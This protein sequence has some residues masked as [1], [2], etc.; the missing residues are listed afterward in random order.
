MSNKEKVA[1]LGPKGTYSHQAA[2]Q[3]F[4]DDTKYELIPVTTIPTC[5][6]NLLYDDNISY[7]IVPLEN[8]TN[9]QVVFTYDLIRDVLK[10]D[11]VEEENL[12]NDDKY[13]NRINPPITIVGEQYVKID[14]CLVVAD[15]EIASKHDTNKYV[16]LYSHPQVWGQVTNYLNTTLKG[17]YQNRIDCKSTSEAM[18]KCKEDAANGIQSLAIGSIT[19]SKMNDCCVIE[20]GINDLKGNTTRFLTFSKKNRLLEIPVNPEDASKD[21]NMTLLT[22]TTL[23]DGPG[24]LVEVLNIFQRYNINMTSISSRPIGVTGKWQ[25][26]FYVEYEFDHKLPWKEEILS[27][28]DSSCLTWAMWGVFPRDNGYYI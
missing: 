14:H 6:E 13:Q 17:K 23:K 22:F 21:N 12:K 26:I 11:Q 10:Q 15:E 20:K 28:I 2:L 18:I 9:G 3:Q 1:F 5:F 7:C 25:Y 24:S 4:P 27:E 19:G 16:N 8:S